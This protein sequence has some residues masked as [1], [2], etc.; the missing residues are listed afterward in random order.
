M[1]LRQARLGEVAGDAPAGALGELVLGEGG[2]EAGGGPALPVGA[3]GEARPDVGDRR[4]A[5]V[6]EQ[7]AEAGGVDGIGSV[8]WCELVGHAASPS[9]SPVRDPAVSAS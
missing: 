6:A 4:Q 9:A 8:P 5:Q 2:E 3:L 1:V 7:Q